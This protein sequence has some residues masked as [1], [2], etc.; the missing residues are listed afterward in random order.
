MRIRGWEG[1]CW[2]K[3]DGIMRR[4]VPTDDAMADM[5][6]AGID[7]LS[8]QG[9]SQ[10]EIEFLPAKALSRDTIRSIG[11]RAAYLGLEW[12]RTPC[13]WPGRA[14][15]SAGYERKSGRFPRES[16][17]SGRSP[18]ERSGATGGGVVPGVA[19][20]ER[21]E[22]RR[23][24]PQV[25]PRHDC[26]ISPAYRHAGGRRTAGKGRRLV[27]ADEPG[28]AAVKRGFRTVYRGWGCCAGT[29]DFVS[30]I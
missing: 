15:D 6:L 23:T 25:W 11:R 21:R 4:P 16:A 27:A 26:G 8:G 20:D 3:V 1:N 13:W 14:H 7:Y 24:G 22:S 19:A 29:P 10:Y 12:M 30:V 28:T 17:G 2:R 5:Y 9:I 18:L